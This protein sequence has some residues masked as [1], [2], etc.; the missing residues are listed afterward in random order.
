MAMPELYVT[1]G[2]R[3]CLGVEDNG[4]I[5]YAKCFS[6]PKASIFDTNTCG[7]AFCAAI[8]LLEWAKW[9]EQASEAPFLGRMSNWMALA[10]G[11]AYSRATNRLGRV[12]SNEVYDLLGHHYLP[13]QRLGNWQQIA[14]GEPGRLGDPSNAK[15]PD[16]SGEFSRLMSF[17]PRTGA[18]GTRP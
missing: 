14:K 11:A 10:T 15:I 5:W 18:A 17:P 12:D 2:A 16:T 1:L 4:T 8:T 9:D 3:G 7:D 6:K 13:G